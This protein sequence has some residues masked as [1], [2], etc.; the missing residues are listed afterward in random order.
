MKGY[1]IKNIKDSFAAQEGVDALYHNEHG[2]CF[3]QGG[4]DL[5]PISRADAAKLKADDETEGGKSSDDDSKGSGA[6]GG[7][8]PGKK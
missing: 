3:T 8:K 1:A 4:G 6:E 7:K 2:H 5:Q